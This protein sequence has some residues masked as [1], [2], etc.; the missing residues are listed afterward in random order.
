MQS[1]LT[2][3]TLQTLP[4]EAIHE[5]RNWSK[6]DVSVAEWPPNTGR[7]IVIKDL[8]PRPLWFRV[9]AGRY[10][11][12]REWRALRTLKDLD[13]VPEAI[14]KPDAD[15]LVIEFK[16]GRQLETIAQDELPD[17]VA[18]KVEQLVSKMHA[19]GVTHGDLHG[20]NILVDDS[21]EVA[22]IDWA[23]ASVFGANPSGAKKFAFEEW[24]A[25]DE[26]A[27][28]KIKVVYTP[29]T[30]TERERDLILNGGSRVYRFVKKFKYGIEKLRGVDEERQAARAAK[31]ELFLRQAGTP[32]ND[33]QSEATE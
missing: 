16:S 14:C 7:K 5:A 3:R 33:T 1:K 26:R 15:C 10:F 28:A 24:R 11:L 8:K 30:L 29:S 6:A 32:A 17:G 9:L 19:R 23:T 25:L 22:L 27:L 12:R 4:R 31:Q 20:N 13:G 21:G 2:R 18:E